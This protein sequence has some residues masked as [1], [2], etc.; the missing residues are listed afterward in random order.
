MPKRF[1]AV[2]AGLMLATAWNA[3]PAAAQPTETHNHIVDA[4]SIRAEVTPEGDITPIILSGNTQAGRIRAWT[5]TAPGWVMDPPVAFFPVPAGVSFLRTYRHD[6]RRLTLRETLS[7]EPA[8]QSLKWEMEINGAKDETVMLETHLAWTDAGAALGFWTAWQESGA[9][10][11]GST[12]YK[13]P[14]QAMP[15]R[16]AVYE[17][18]DEMS[19]PIATLMDASKDLGVSLIQSPLDF[20]MDTRLRVAQSGEVAF[21]RKQHRLNGVEPLRFT[22]YITAH[23]ADWRDGLG[24]MT[25]LFPDAFNPA[26]EKAY[27]VDGGGVYSR[28]EGDLDVPKFRKMALGFNWKASFDFPYMGMFIPPINDTTPFQS[29]GSGTRTVAQMADYSRR[30]A[31]AGFHVLNYFNITEAGNRIRSPAPARQATND[32]DLW[33]DA[34]DFVY[35]AMADA[36]LRSTN[37]GVTYSDWEG[38]VVMDP[39]EPTYL[40]YLEQQA[41]RHITSLP[42]SS[43]VC[44]DRL[45]HLRRFNQHAPDD[46]ITGDG[47]PP[48]RSLM[49]SWHTAMKR[50]A[51]IFHEAG[52]VIL[53]NPIG[54]YRID[55]IR[56]LDG[57]YDEYRSATNINR[58]AFLC[59]RKPLTIWSAPQGDEGFQ[60]AL[61]L[62]AFPSVPFPGNDHNVEPDPALEQQFLNYGLLLNAVRGKKWVL[63]PHVI[64]VE[65]QTALANLF[66]TPYGYAAPVMFGG[67]AARAKVVIR[68]LPIKPERIDAL[69]PGSESAVAVA[70]TSDGDTITL[71]VPLARGCA[72]VRL[73]RTAGK[74][75]E[76]NTTPIPRA[77]TPATRNLIPETVCATP[78]Y[79]CT[80]TRQFYEAEKTV[81]KMAELEGDEVANST[82]RCLAESNLF[83]AEGWAAQYFP[84]VKKDLFLMFDDGWDVPASGS[85]A[86]FGIGELDAGRFPSCDGQPAERLKKLANLARNA[87]WRGIGLWICAQ[88]YPADPEK[89]RY[90][91]AKQYEL[92]YW[93][94]RLK[95]SHEAGVAYWKVDWGAKGGSAEYRRLISD[96]ASKHAPGLIVEHAICMD[97]LNL[98]ADHRIEKRIVADAHVLLEFSDVFRVYD[99][100]TQ[101]PIPTTLDRTSE[102]LRFQGHS[103]TILN[104]DDEVYIAAALGGAAGILRFPVESKFIAEDPYYSFNYGEKFLTTRDANR[105]IDEVVRLV[106]WQK[107]MPAFALGN[108]TNHIDEQT[109]SDAWRFARGDTWDARIIG[110]RVEQR[111]PARLSRNMPLPS[112]EAGGP[113]PF[114]VAA[115]D[116]AGVVAVATLGRV[117]PESAYQ[118]VLADVGIQL[119][120]KPKNYVGVFGFYK[121]LTLTFDQPPDKPVIWAQDLA[122]KGAVDITDRTT[123]QGYGG[124]IN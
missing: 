56:H 57:I 51:P 90:S 97:P 94:K 42:F 106:N 81:K 36:W 31:G 101:L 85:E 68:G 65:N 2:L 53:G 108:S 77:T 44:I 75:A 67:A 64:S 11:F 93:T 18:G 100:T 84:S 107:I 3:L 87:G 74:S 110:K 1:V 21:S 49:V 4:G 122:G 119:P 124:Q 70:A 35:Y 61:Y 103:Q 83:S 33:K 6:G 104:F 99:A 23:K 69:Q 13:N 39:A 46:G 30:M 91:D 114:V 66:E 79:W 28:Y 25:R 80:W 96:L 111:A 109:L 29:F 26:N 113:P 112:V 120:K 60:E 16:D 76:G 55:V 58:D 15:M 117:T 37:G 12:A 71:D 89:Q 88:E 86:Y 102:Y 50:L 17:L 78:S 121:S 22:V 43:G 82:R 92:D 45:D 52:K 14:L 5:R 123:V 59:V 38:C 54:A 98:S 72:L 9:G 8:N 19:V 34:N 62:A 40:A 48:G 116:P 24:R 7:P 20:L 95:W 115:T 41:R 10:P 32:A 63:L 73:T 27:E 47:K 105:R 118:P